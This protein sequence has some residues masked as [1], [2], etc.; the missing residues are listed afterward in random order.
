[1]SGA[2]AFFE[3]SGE[4]EMNYET[5]EFY[6]REKLWVAGKGMRVRICSQRDLPTS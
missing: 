2:P 5:F 4:E 3:L 6:G 1:M